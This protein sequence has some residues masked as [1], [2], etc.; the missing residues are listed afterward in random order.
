MLSLQF[1]ANRLDVGRSRNGRDY[2]IV[3]YEVGTDDDEKNERHHTA[4][5]IQ[6]TSEYEQK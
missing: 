2:M 3:N 6:P 5:K 1:S 4:D